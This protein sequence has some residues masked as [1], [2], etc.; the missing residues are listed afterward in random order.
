[1]GILSDAVGLCDAFNNWGIGQTLERRNQGD[2]LQS[3]SIR[4]FDF[5]QKVSLCDR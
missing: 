3:V 2:D 4:V 5:A 1:M